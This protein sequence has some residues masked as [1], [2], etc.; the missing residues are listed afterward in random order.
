MGTGKMGK[1]RQ[2]GDVLS[3]F[4]CSAS[5]G[6]DAGHSRRSCP[7]RSHHRYLYSRPRTRRPWVECG[8]HHG[9][10]GAGEACSS[11]QQHGRALPR[12]DHERYECDLQK[13]GEYDRPDVLVPLADHEPT[14]RVKQAA[15]RVALGVVER[16]DF[17]GGQ[18]QQTGR[19]GH[20]GSCWM[21][22]SAVARMGCRGRR[23]GDG[24]REQ[25]G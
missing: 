21:S 23:R 25:V 24:R 22:E 2:G 14:G 20:P 7:P 5:R 12:H 9:C 4:S 10:V 13:A 19:M 16:R 8:K 17:L 18:V 6:P 15:L 11:R 1:G 3:A